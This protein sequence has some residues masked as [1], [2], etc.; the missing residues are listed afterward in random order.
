MVLRSVPCSSRWVANEWRSM[1]TCTRCLI[2][3]RLAASFSTFTRALAEY[4]SP[5]LSPS[6]NH[7]FGRYSLKYSLRSFSSFSDSSEYRHFR[8]LPIIRTSILS[9]MMSFGVR[10]SSS[11][12]RNPAEYINEIMQRCFRFDRHARMR[13]TT[14]R[15]NTSG[16]DLYSFARM[17]PP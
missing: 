13:P 14:L 11:L 7:F 5:G 12:L 6:N 17:M 15:L 8:P 2:P 4:C 10:F 1:C 3:A 16:S 9:L